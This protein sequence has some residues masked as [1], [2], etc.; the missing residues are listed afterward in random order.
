MLQQQPWGGW[1]C[2]DSGR[3]DCATQP[4]ATSDKTS[5]SAAVRQ[6]RLHDEP[7]GS[8]L[9]CRCVV[10]RSDCQAGCAPQPAAAGGHSIPCQHGAAA[11]GEAVLWCLSGWAPGGR[12]NAGSNQSNRPARADGHSL[13]Q[14]AAPTWGGES[15]QWSRGCGQQPSQNC[16]Q[17]Q[18]RSLWFSDLENNETIHS[19]ALLAQLPGPRRLPEHAARQPAQRLFDARACLLAGVCQVTSLS[20]QHQHALCRHAL[21]FKRGHQPAGQAMCEWQAGKSKEGPRHRRSRAC[22]VTRAGCSRAWAGAHCNPQCPPRAPDHPPTQPPT[23]P[24]ASAA[25]VLSDC[26]VAFE[27]G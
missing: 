9:L 10:R 20:L 14:R 26:L 1:L 5:A 13:T 6:A 16:T 23:H 3:P 2:K 21:P 4:Q 22:T 27:W 8:R 15:V 24:R 12:I 19:C 18:A 25:L 7:L 11:Q 17:R